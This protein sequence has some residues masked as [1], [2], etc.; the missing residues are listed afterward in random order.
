MTIRTNFNSIALVAAI[1]VGVTGLASPA[2]AGETIELNQYDLTRVE[3]A[4]RLQLDI[5]ASATDLCREKYR[6]WVHAGLH[7]RIDACIELAVD[8]AVAQAKSE[9]L[10]KLHASID[11]KVRYDTRRSPMSQQSASAQ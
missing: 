9:N 1:V 8:N 3:D 6:A 5:V 4:D 11:S 10:N 7:R 2:I